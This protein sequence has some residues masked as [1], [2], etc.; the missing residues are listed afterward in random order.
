MPPSRLLLSTR[1]SLLHFQTLYRNVSHSSNIHYVKVKRPWFRKFITRLMLSGTAVYLWSSS[2]VVRKDNSLYDIQ[3]RNGSPE[4]PSISEEPGQSFTKGI[5]I[6]IT[7]AESQARDFYAR[8][9]PEWKVFM[10][11]QKDS[12]RMA[13]IKGELASL[14]LSEASQSNLLSR[15]LGPPFSLRET[16]LLHQFPTRAPAVINIS[17]VAI[18]DTGISWVKMPMSNDMLR[19]SA[20]P[21]F[22]ALAVKDAF[23]SLWGGLINRLNAINIVDQRALSLSVSSS[24]TLLPSDLKTLDKLG[25]TSLSEP[26][27]TPTNSPQSSTGRNEGRARSHHL[28]ILSTIG[29]LPLPKFGPG[30]E[31]YAASLAFKRRINECRA[32]DLRAHRRGT[33]FVRGPV[34][35]K[36]SK[37]T[38]RIEVEGLYD[39]KASE[40]VFVSMQLKDMSS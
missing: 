39:P 32:Q 4:K 30:T 10:E 36:G 13:S 27:L 22:I 14:V 17:G 11:L 1:R 2:A 20:R 33:F 40:W 31:L 23:L 38:C 8:S 29:W 37:G 5:F 24:K 18:T 15:M 26:E 35:V 3:S 12:K 21:Y 6:P 34:C 19:R 28:S 16:W 25:E 9:D 7:W